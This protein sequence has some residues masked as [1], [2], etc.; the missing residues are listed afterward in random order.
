MRDRR[1]GQRVVSGGT[2]GTVVIGGAVAQ[3]PRQAGHTWQFLQYML[4][5]R[6][7]GWD[8]LLID[9]LEAGMSPDPDSNVRYLVE[10]M[11]SFGL[12]DS[13]SLLLDDGEVIGVPR[14]ELLERVSSSAV[15]INFMGFVD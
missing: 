3:K 5:F 9:R 8:V 11:E 13:Y 6:R 15:L 10:V 7:L 14:R 12:E 4:G 1:F 2:R